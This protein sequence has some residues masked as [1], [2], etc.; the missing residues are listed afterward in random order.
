MN[1]GYSISPDT[2]RI[3]GSRVNFFQIMVSCLR[4]L[5]KHIII[6]MTIYYSDIKV[7]FNE[8]SNYHWYH[9]LLSNMKKRTY[10]YPFR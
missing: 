8:Y 2:L 9:F 10:S 1:N 5:K 3:N 4:N 7:L 6:Y